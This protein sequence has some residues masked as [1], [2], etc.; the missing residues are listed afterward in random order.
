MSDSFNTTVA[1]WQGVDDEPTSGS[2]NLVKSGGVDNKLAELSAL[3]NIIY[4]DIVVYNETQITDGW[5]IDKLLNNN[6]L[7]IDYNGYSTSPFIDNNN[8]YGSPAFVTFI[9]DDI[10]WSFPNVCF[11]KKSTHEY[12]SGLDVA[13][14][15][16]NEITIE[17]PTGYSVRISV[18]RTTNLLV[19]YSSTVRKKSI[20][21]GAVTTSKIADG[22]VTTSKI[23]DGAVTTSKIADGAVSIK[24]VDDSISTILDY[25]AIAGQGTLDAE[26]IASTHNWT[27]GLL[28]DNGN[29]QEYAGYF[30]TDFI[31]NED[32]YGQWSVVEVITPNAYS[33]DN[34]FFYNK[35]DHSFVKSL[36]V[37]GGNK[38]LIQIPSNY[39]VRITTT[40]KR[41]LKF[42]P[43]MGNV[44]DVSKIADAAVTRSKIADG[45]VTTS[46]IADAVNIQQKEDRG[47]TSELATRIVGK[48]FTNNGGTTTNPKGRGNLQEQSGYDTII[49]AIS[50]D[51]TKL[52]L[53]NINIGVYGG[54]FLVNIDDESTN[55][56]FSTSG[57]GEKIMS[58][59]DSANYIGLTMPTAYSLPLQWIKEYSIY[60]LKGLRIPSDAFKG[61]PTPN[62]HF[63]GKKI[64]LI[65]T[66]VAYGQK[67]TKAYMKIA[68]ERLG[69]HIVPAGLP[70]EAIH[71]KI[72]NGQ[73]KPLTY[74]S[75]CLS[76]AEYAS[77]GWAIPATANPA[78]E[79]D[80][81]PTKG[82]NN[83]YRTWENIF[84]EQN[85]DVDLWVFATAPNNTNFA[86]TD[87]D[88]F[89]KGSF[90]YGD[91]STF[92]EHRT[93]FLGA[94][95]FLMDK[96]YK[97]NP[98]ARMV[99][100]LDSA[101][102]YNDGKSNFKL[103][104]ERYGIPI[105]DLWGKITTTPQ[106][107]RVIRSE[108]GTD[109][110]PSTFGHERMG[111]MVTNELLL[112]S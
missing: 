90:S 5:E 49:Y 27:N 62:N 96:M 53:S 72:E 63:Y 66:S 83:Y 22:A 103:L 40:D 51:W 38:R 39:S 67:S 93:T 17:I 28:L 108:G 20:A 10:R 105:I 76:I 13:S 97:L 2:D 31:D 74:G 33:Y 45:A 12:V 71:A 84:S 48:L 43:S 85:A 64:G 110:H 107:L 30:T 58:I 35:R 44:N 23:A 46:K 52:D 87:W 55:W 82:Y 41:Y 86:T 14:G 88:I 19:G 50:K 56:A 91:G 100:L 73:L 98:N 104:S 16:R 79:V 4:E 92:E 111:D 21:D 25:A 61:T 60:E 94:M 81:E 101:F 99:L 34:V 36:R 42:Q 18:C 32:Y 24:S 29:I 59:P 6:G 9:G 15:S 109:N 54:A 47:S 11:Y 112:I 89:D 7:L 95:L 3:N 78:S 70:G 80:W 77:A 102:A 26:N 8:L 75:T 65:G 37:Y 106:S 1:N 68:G 57:G 69:F